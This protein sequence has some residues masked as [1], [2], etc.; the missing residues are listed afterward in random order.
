MFRKSSGYFFSRLK[1]QQ[2]L[3]ETLLHDNWLHNQHCI[4]I[5]ITGCP[6]LEVT[7]N[8]K[9]LASSI[10]KLLSFKQLFDANEMNQ[11]Q[12]GRAAFC[13]KKYPEF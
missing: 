8:K 9:Q 6:I 11:S 2:F 3:T 12:V 5:I 13:K 10:L 4:I 7:Y 1:I